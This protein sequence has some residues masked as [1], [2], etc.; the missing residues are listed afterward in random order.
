VYAWKW[1]S[2]GGALPP[3][4][5]TLASRQFYLKFPRSCVIVY[6]NWPVSF[7]QIHV[8]TK[9]KIAHLITQNPME[10]Q[11]QNNKSDSEELLC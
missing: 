10:T 8:I 2:A 9:H 5:V 7:K 1:F 11:V 4:L 3:S 6:I